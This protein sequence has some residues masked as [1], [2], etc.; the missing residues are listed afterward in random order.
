[1]LNVFGQTATFWEMM[2][3]MMMMMI[4]IIIISNTASYEY[5]ITSVLHT[6]SVFAAFLA[7]TRQMLGL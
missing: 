2:M 6:V 5:K 1:L 4:I 7:P 3:M